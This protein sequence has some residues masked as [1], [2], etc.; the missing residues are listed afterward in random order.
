MATL[1]SDYNVC[2][3]LSIVFAILLK[4]LSSANLSSDAIKIVKEK[5]RL[6]SVGPTIEPLGTPNILFCKLFFSLFIRSHCFLLSK[7]E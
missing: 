1:Y 2:I 5:N 4:L 3:K 6:Y 7:Y